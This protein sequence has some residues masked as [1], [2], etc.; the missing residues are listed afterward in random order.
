MTPRDFD[1]S[2]P[3]VQALSAL[4]AVLAI[5]AIHVAAYLALLPPAVQML[6][7]QSFLFAFSATFAF[8]LVLSTAIA[9]YLPT[10][11]FGFLSFIHTNVV[12][13]IYARRGYKRALVSHSLTLDGERS[14]GGI[15]RRIS[16]HFKSLEHFGRN[17]ARLANLR[18]SVFQR[19]FPVQFYERHRAY[20]TIILSIAVMGLFYVGFLR[21][22]LV[23]IVLAIVLISFQFYGL[24]ASDFRF[25]L[26]Q[27]I[28]NQMSQ[29]GS[30][31]DWQEEIHH[32]VSSVVIGSAL[33]GVMKLDYN[34]SHAD[35]SVL[36][37]STIGEYKLMG[38]TSSGLLLFDVTQGDYQLA[39]FSNVSWVRADH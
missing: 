27:E 18:K 5:G 30:E 1:F 28:W 2:K 34:R 4:V 24:F 13:A 31:G 20:V 39:P 36:V 8:G 21:S 3:W 15:R 29:L 9:R 11:T 25:R 6:V 26:S 35:V 38:V 17:E 22:L 10:V 12:D 23:L 14:I 7:D 32:L 33:L 16:S 37:G 19:S